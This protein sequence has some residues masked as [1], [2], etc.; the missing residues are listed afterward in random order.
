MD[1]SATS[2]TIVLIA[3]QEVVSALMAFHNEIKWE[4]RENSSIDR[5]DKLLQEL[6]LAIRKDIGLSKKDSPSAF[7][8]HLIGTG[9]RK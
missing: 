6:I 9:P 3:S 5:H 4:N 7:D 1:F 8:F 2:N